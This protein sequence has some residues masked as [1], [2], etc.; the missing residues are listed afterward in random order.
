MREPSNRVLQALAETLNGKIPVIGA[1]GILSGADAVRKMQLGA[2]AVQ[3]Y[4]GMVYRG[5][6]LV[7]ECLQHIR[8]AGSPNH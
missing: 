4:S 5:P 6:K 3:L 2:Q 1:G 7:E 8:A